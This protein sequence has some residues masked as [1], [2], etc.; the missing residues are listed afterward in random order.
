MSSD[1]GLSPSLGS[2]GLRPS[3]LH[4]TVSTVG[5]LVPQIK[6]SEIVA[7]VWIS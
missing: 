4:H 1:E 5:L 6:E 7:L 3:L 2:E